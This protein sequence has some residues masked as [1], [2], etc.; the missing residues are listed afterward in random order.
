[1]PWL[2]K[3]CVLQLLMLTMNGYCYTIFY[4]AWH[5]G[6]SDILHQFRPG[7]LNL[8]GIASCQVGGISEPAGGVSDVLKNEAVIHLNR[9]LDEFQRYFPD[10]KDNPTIEFT[11]DPFNFRVDNFP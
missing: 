1:M 9:L 10:I 8:W 2:E 5:I 6:E 4:G 7:V 3:Y 11:W